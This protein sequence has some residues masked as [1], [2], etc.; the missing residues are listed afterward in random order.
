MN[1]ALGK[2]KKKKKK[3]AKSAECVWGWCAPEPRD[4]SVNGNLG[5]LYHWITPADDVSEDDQMAVISPASA[6]VSSG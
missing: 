6:Q 3:T 5:E 4:E 1:E 2:R